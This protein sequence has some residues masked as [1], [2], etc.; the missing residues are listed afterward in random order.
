MCVCVCAGIDGV[1]SHSE[2]C[3]CICVCVSMCIYIYIP[4]MIFPVFNVCPDLILLSTISYSFHAEL[5]CS[6][7]GFVFGDF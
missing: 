2:V 7:S 4:Y 6:I 1:L 5:T 3:V